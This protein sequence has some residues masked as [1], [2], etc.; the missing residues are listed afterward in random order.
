MEEVNYF[1][2]EGGYPG[3]RI[4]DLFNLSM[5]LV[6]QNIYSQSDFFFSSVLTSGRLE[7]SCIIGKGQDLGSLTLVRDIEFVRVDNCRRFDW[8]RAF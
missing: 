2:E 3:L 4:E 6:Y 1:L 8:V 7:I 5:R